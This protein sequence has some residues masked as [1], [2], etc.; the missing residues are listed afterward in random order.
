LRQSRRARLLTGTLIAGALSLGFAACGDD[1]EDSGGE[2]AATE[3][4]A[5]TVEVVATEYDFELS[6]TPSADTQEVTF[7]NQGEEFH[8]MIFAR[9][10][11]GHTLEEAIKAQGEKGT[12]T[13][14]AEAEAE[15]GKSTTVEV[16]EE[17][18]PGS[19]AMLCPIEGPEGAHY[20]LGQLEEFELQ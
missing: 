17:I 19:Y 5:A 14:I 18:G 16:Q 1:G 11:E 7:D 2:E 8:V 3:E 12:A 4:S 15:P 20:E 9:I 10:N 13:T 6:A